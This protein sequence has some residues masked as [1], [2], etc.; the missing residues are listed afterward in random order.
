MC[1]HAS[2]R[3]TTLTNTVLAQGLIS[4]FEF[5]KAMARVHDYI[6]VAIRIFVLLPTM[7]S[8]HFL[9]NRVIVSRDSSAVYASRS[10]L[11]NQRSKEDLGEAPGLSIALSSQVTAFVRYR[12]NLP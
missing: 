3:D 6:F 12:S 1:F 8:I 9:N 7:A 10:S 4:S 2:Y 11:L 5:T